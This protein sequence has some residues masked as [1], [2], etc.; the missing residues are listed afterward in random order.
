MHQDQVDS[1]GNLSAIWSMNGAKETKR[2]GG[3]NSLFFLFSPALAN[4][5]QSSCVS[6]SVLYALLI[7]IWGPRQSISQRLV[8]CHLALSQREIVERATL[9][10]LGCALSAHCQICT[11]IICGAVCTPYKVENQTSPKRSS[12]QSTKCTVPHRYLASV[13]IPATHR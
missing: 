11:A 8:S 6:A 12:V 5:T 2:G 1:A 10:P 3:A 13:S 9:H 7:E 4:R